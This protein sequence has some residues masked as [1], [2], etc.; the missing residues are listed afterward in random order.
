MSKIDTVGRET[1][2]ES[3]DADDSSSTQEDEDADD[4][5]DDDD[6]DEDDEKEPAVESPARMNR[7]RKYSLTDINNAN[8][9]V[10][11]ISMAN[12]KV[13]DVISSTNGSNGNTNSTVHPAG[14]SF[15]GRS[16]SV[17][18]TNTIESTVSE[19]DDGVITETDDELDYPRKKAR[20]MSACDTPASGITAE[21]PG[22][23]TAIEGLNGDNGDE[24][25][26]S[27]LVTDDLPDEGDLEIEEVEAQELAREFELEGPDFGAHNTG[28]PQIP[29]ESELSLYDGLLTDEE[30]LGEPGLPRADD[31]SQWSTLSGLLYYDALISDDLFS[32]PVSREDTPATP[33]PHPSQSRSPVLHPELLHSDEWSDDEEDRVDPELD[34]PFFDRQDP[35]VRHVVNSQTWDSAWMDS[36]SED[37]VWKYCFSSGG[38]TSG[39]SKA[40]SRNGNEQIG[41]ED[42]N[43]DCKLC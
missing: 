28:S 26:D 20:P 37:D 33:T 27:S 14:R 18:S 39:E 12:A 8:T 6:D 41:D 34:N 30:Y 42:E 13:I 2:G 32:V 7:K 25:D 4:E 23:E 29:A 40:E 1:G 36:E 10:Y 19:F 38:S 9:T 22:S 21:D 3:S 43:Y 11:K 17:T 5:N 24:E 31:P 16:F 35:A 15:E